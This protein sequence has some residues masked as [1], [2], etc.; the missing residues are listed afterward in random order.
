MFVK[1]SESTVVCELTEVFMPEYLY[2]FAKYLLSIE[3]LLSKID[4]T[5]NDITKNVPIWAEVFLIQ[6]F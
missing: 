3:K 4:R 2:L 5:N 6:I 1:K